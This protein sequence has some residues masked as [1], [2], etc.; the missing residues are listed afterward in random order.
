[1]TI[2]VVVSL[3]VV[4]LALGLAAPYF[5]VRYLRKHMQENLDTFTRQLKEQRNGKV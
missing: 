3:I 2:V 5:H 1:M 4:L